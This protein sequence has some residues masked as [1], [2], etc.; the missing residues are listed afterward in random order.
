[1]SFLWAH[2][3]CLFS[4]PSENWAS[5]IFHKKCISPMS[6]LFAGWLLSWWVQEMEQ[7]GTLRKRLQEKWGKKIF[8]DLLKPKEEIMRVN[9]FLYKRRKYKV[10]LA[11]TA[12]ACTN[13][14]IW[15]SG[16]YERHESHAVP[17][18]TLEGR[19]AASHFVVQSTGNNLFWTKGVVGSDCHFQMPA[20]VSVQRMTVTGTDIWTGKTVPSAIFGHG[21]C[22]VYYCYHHW[23]YSPGWRP[24]LRS[25]LLLA[26]AAC[27]YCKRQSLLPGQK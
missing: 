19:S 22:H 10:K 25:D 6:R 18:S 14:L 24:C 23:N 9:F 17:I 3:S 1:M 20:F 15:F 5:H 26:R 8:G 21:Y 11:C 16:S 2:S 13:H 4:T 27:K 12:E 7:T